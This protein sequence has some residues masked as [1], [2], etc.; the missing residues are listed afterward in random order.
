MIP[1]VEE[2]TPT[3]RR[4]K[5]IVRVWRDWD[6]RL[7]R[8]LPANRGWFWRLI[9]PS[10]L[11]WYFPALAAA[12]AVGMA[13]G[14][15]LKGGW[16]QGLLLAAGLAGLA[17]VHLRAMRQVSR[18]PSHRYLPQICGGYLAVLFAMVVWLAAFAAPET[19]RAPGLRL[20]IGA[21][22]VMVMIMGL[23]GALLISRTLLRDREAG[24]LAESLGRTDLFSPRERYQSTNRGWIFT[25]AIYALA[26]YP[27]RILLPPALLML[28][29]TEGAREIWGRGWEG[30]RWILLLVAALPWG[31]MVVGLPHERLLEL[32]ETF[33]RL[34]FTGPQRVV[35]WLVIAISALR[36]FHVHY[37]NYLFTG[38]SWTIMF[39]LGFAYVVAWFYGFWCDVFFATRLLCALAPA[40]GGETSGPFGYHVLNRPEIGNGQAGAG[41][42]SPYSSVLTGGRSLMLHGAGRIKVEGRHEADY[43]IAEGIKPRA[44]ALLTPP[45]VM[46]KIRD[47]V[48]NRP[49]GVPPMR[50]LR[51]V[52]RA[53]I[54]YP[55][56]TASLAMALLVVPGYYSF[57][58]STQP[59]ELVIRPV[60][61]HDGSLRLETLLKGEEAPASACP[62]HPGGRRILIAA[63][64]GGSR[65]ALYTYSVLRG[66]AEE[67]RICELAAASG[68]SGGAVALAYF[69]AHQWDLRRPLP[70]DPAEA[71]KRARQWDEFGRAMQV[72]YI[73]DV[74][75][76]LGNLR[77]TFGRWTWRQSACKELPAPP[78]QVDSLL[79]P[80]RTRP[81]NVLAEDFICT[82]GPA[83]FENL[84]FGLIL[85]TGLLGRFDTE[86]TSCAMG[87][88]SLA[89]RARRC[90]STLDGTGAG[91]RLVLTNLPALD[92]PSKEAARSDIWLRT[93]NAPG[94]AVA[95]AAALSANFPPV[96]PD[97]AID[98]TSDGRRGQRYWVTDG[99]A[100]ENRAAVTLYIALR[101]A[102]MRLG[103]LPGPVDLV[104]ADAS[105]TA[106][107]YSESF[108]LRSAT[109]AGAQLALAMEAE[110]RRDIEAQPGADRLFRVHEL[111]MPRTLLD[112]IGTHW[113][114]PE[115]LVIGS[116]AGRWRSALGSWVGAVW[117]AAGARIRGADPVLRLSRDDAVR[118]FDCLY[119]PAGGVPPAFRD[120]AELRRVL[121]RMHTEPGTWQDGAAWRRLIGTPNQPRPGAICPL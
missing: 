15:N 18:L 89:D 103:S 9:A 21:A 47:Q 25:A 30:E 16:P 50:L 75:G 3:G 42:P 79:N 27:D 26:R 13:F 36:V 4:I 2:E 113:R 24:A 81:G 58:F 94:I 41:Q 22:L 52:Q 51:D 43:C 120:G 87:A 85:N 93:L 40:E 95:R 14:P 8:P 56:L 111:P 82:L 59:A 77:L 33:G 53:A 48:E 115:Q 64:G 66:L 72:S 78:G 105:A 110:L 12:A 5:R 84:P 88:G 116:G 76:E 38:E 119:R 74:I 19:F 7:N 101:D 109:G 86:D 63:S 31:L 55:T 83:T 10:G 80:A 69:A 108:G 23:G 114:M 60:P 121:A 39:F 71:E 6:T 54:V 92:A 11:A 20:H 17:I 118:I 106:D 112:A 96:F 100:V 44:L 91:G 62:A 73:D 67:G 65:A 70:A 102:V 37:V 61:G 107:P 97:A 35:T 57:R 49:E 104:I 32:L 28:A 90:A 68:V 1:A 98:V 29:T 99:G 34:A 117:P 45:Q 46:E